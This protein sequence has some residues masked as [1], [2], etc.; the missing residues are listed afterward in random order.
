MR[1]ELMTSSLPR[2]RSTPELHRHFSLNTR[3]TYTHKHLLKDQKFQAKKTFLAAQK[4]RLQRQALLII[5]T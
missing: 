2:K 4:T 3:E 5:I 1:F